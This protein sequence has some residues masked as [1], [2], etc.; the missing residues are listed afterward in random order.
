MEKTW[1]DIWD[2]DQGFII[3]DWYNAGGTPG[4]EGL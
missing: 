4:K 3:Y 2:K 1:Y